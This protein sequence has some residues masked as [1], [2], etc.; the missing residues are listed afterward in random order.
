MKKSLLKK[1]LVGIREPFAKQWAKVPVMFR[2]VALVGV[3]FLFMQIAL[4]VIN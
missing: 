2:G 4:F 3:L 1:F